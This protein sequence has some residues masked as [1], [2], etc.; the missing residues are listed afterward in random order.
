MRR[1]SSKLTGTSTQIK[2][3]Y[4]FTNYVVMSRGAHVGMTRLHTLLSLLATLT[5][6]HSPKDTL[7]LQELKSLMALSQGGEGKRLRSAQSTQQDRKQGEGHWR[8]SGR[9]PAAP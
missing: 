6:A 7:Q 2:K 9:L 1:V 3:L 8:R 4:A 5:A